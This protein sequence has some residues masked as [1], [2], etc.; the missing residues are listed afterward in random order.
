MYPVLKLSLT[1]LTYLL[2]RLIRFICVIVSY[3]Q[4]RIICNIINY[5]LAITIGIRYSSP[6]LMEQHSHGK[7][8]ITVPKYIILHI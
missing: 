5:T 6:K 7:N 3:C 2:I 1:P 4:T 8:Y